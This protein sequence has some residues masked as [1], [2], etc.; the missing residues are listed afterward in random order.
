MAAPKRQPLNRERILAA[1]VD[2]G[3]P[4]RSRSAQHAQAGRGARGRSYVTL[5]P[6][7][8]QRRAPGRN[9]RSVSTRIGNPAGERRLGSSHPGGLPPVSGVGPRA[10]Q[11]LSPAHSAPAGHDGRSLAGGD[12]SRDAATGGVRRLDGAP[13]LPH[14]NQLHRRLRHVRDPGASPW[15]LEM[16]GWAP[17]HYSPKNSRA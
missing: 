9:G 17:A 15:N 12:F 1:A 8:E 3:R 11:R 13:G 5:Q 14:A 4:G 7:A 10:P 2:F 6:R 16:A